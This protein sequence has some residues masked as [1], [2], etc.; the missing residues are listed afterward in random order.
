MA[1]KRYKPSVL[2]GDLMEILWGSAYNTQNHS[3]KLRL[4]FRA[5]RGM[6]WQKGTDVPFITPFYTD[7]QK[8]RLSYIRI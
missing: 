7:N 2:N 1:A 4:W 3:R 6:T 5:V 8:L